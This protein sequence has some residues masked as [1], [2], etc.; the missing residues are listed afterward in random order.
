MHPW[1]F[2]SH[3]ESCRLC[4][5]RVQATIAHWFQV[6][7]PATAQDLAE[8]LSLVSQLQAAAPE[9]IKP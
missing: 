2:K 3:L 6:Q 1:N 9:Y 5:P 7:G 8:A 4:K